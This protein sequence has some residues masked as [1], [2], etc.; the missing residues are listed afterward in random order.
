MPVIASQ[1]GTLL[2][3][4]LHPACHRSSL[5]TQPCPLPPP[6]RPPPPSTPCL[7]PCWAE[8]WLWL[9]GRRGEY[10]SKHDRAAEALLA[11][12]ERQRSSACPCCRRPLLSMLPFHRLQANCHPGL[13]ALVA[14][15]LGIMV[16]C[17]PED[18][19]PCETAGNTTGT[20]NG[21][22]YR[23]TVWHKFPHEEQ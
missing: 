19:C 16:P 18:T 3:I 23:L 11:P 8:C 10:R 5:A 4:P 6:T 15:L 22:G 12:P 1:P 17:M 13:Q 14:L 20:C 21:T 7:T 2:C 9:A